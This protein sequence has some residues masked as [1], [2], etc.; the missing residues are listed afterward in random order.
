MD[1]P[2]GLEPA[3]AGFEYVLSEWSSAE[4]D[5]LHDRHN[6]I[7]TVLTSQ[8]HHVVIISSKVSHTPPVHRLRCMLYRY[9]LKEKEK[10]ICKLPTFLH[11]TTT[12]RLTICQ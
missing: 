3:K 7:T 2:P 9:L 6:K 5:P 10:D 12:Q 1:Q 8:H 11:R 4:S